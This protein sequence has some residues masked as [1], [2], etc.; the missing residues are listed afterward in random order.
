MTIATAARDL[1]AAVRKRVLFRASVI[2]PDGIHR[3][4]VN[5]LTTAGARIACEWPP[6]VGSD[7]IF[8]RGDLFVAGRVA[9]STRNGAGIEFYRP[10]D[11]P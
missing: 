10:L 1:R 6:R 3:V 4:R 8:Q 11:Q 7:V 9:W 2:T 5:D